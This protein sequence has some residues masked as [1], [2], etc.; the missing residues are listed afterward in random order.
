MS[1]QAEGLHR[2]M[3]LA[4]DLLSVKRMADRCVPLVSNQGQALDGYAELENYRRIIAKMGELL[5]EGE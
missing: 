3:G 4:N 5:K 1:D 2:L